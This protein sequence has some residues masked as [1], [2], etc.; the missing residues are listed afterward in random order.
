LIGNELVGT[1]TTIRRQVGISVFVKFAQG[2]RAPQ[3]AISQ[4]EALDMY[5]LPVYILNLQIDSVKYNKLTKQLEVTYRNTEAQA[6]YFKGTYSLTGS[7]G[8][9]QTVGDIDPVFIDGNSLKTVVYDVEALAE[10]DIIADVYTIY[11]ESK[12]SLEKEIRETFCPTCARQV[13]IIQII[14]NCKVIVTGLTYDKRAGYFSVRTVNQGSVDC[15]TRVDLTDIIIT[16]E[17][18]TFSSDTVAQIKVGQT[19]DIR[20]KAQLTDADITQ[21]TNVHVKA[22]YGERQDRLIKIFEGDFL[23]VLKGFDYVFWSLILVIIILILLI[24]W[25]RQKEKKKRQPF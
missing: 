5:Y 18:N 25:R 17:K 19:E 16:G 3:G 2:A 4:V 13:Q 9:K 6:V 11:G 20:V 14:D 24:I 23:L 15:Y 7:D 12:N 10:G 1:A 21:N 8:A 22:Y